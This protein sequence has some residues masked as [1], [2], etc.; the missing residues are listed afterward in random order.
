MP[1]MRNLRPERSADGLDLL[2]EPAAHL[3]AGIAAGKADHAVLLEEFVGEFVAAAL[4]KPGILLAGVEAK[5][6]RR[7]DRKGRILADVIIRDRM[8]HLDGVVGGRVKRL[9]ARNDFARREQLNLKLVVGHFRNLFRKI[10]S[11]AVDRIERFREARGHAPLDLGRGLRDRRRGHCGGGGTG[12]GNFQK[13]TTLHS[14]IS[15]LGHFFPDFLERF[16]FGNAHQ[17]RPEALW[18]A[19]FNTEICQRNTRQRHDSTA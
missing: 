10:L 3:G 8:A 17:R 15:L 18:R 12:R 4:G 9:Q 1:P 2:A 6:H 19:V 16:P 13:I 5:R 14:G 11:G 7:E